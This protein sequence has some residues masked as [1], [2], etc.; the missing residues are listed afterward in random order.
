MALQFNNT[1]SDKVNCGHATSLANFDL[2]TFC[3]W[4]KWDGTDQFKYVVNKEGGN[5]WESWFNDSGL[6]GGVVANIY[7]AAGASTRAHVISNDNLFTANVWTFLAVSLDSSTVSNNKVYRGTLTSLLSD[8]TKDATRASTNPKGDDSAS[9]FLIANY[10]FVATYSW[11]GQMA[12]ATLY[13]RV[14]TLGELKQIQ[15][16]LLPLSGCVV[17]IQLGW[18]GLG[19][20]PDWSGQKNNGTL[21]GSPTVAPHVPIVGGALPQLF[22]SDSRL[23][24]IGLV[25]NYRVF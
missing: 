3:L 18:N 2:F 24:K 21:V 12:Y 23:D 14:L 17:N 10:P 5:G 8:Q 13:N 6:G 9:D 15:F 4:M 22:L 1:N 19:I 11:A 7:T 20:Q 25:G 16:G